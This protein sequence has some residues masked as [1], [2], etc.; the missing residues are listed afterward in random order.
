MDRRKLL[1]DLAVFCDVQ[2]ARIKAAGEQERNDYAR[3]TL[4]I[5]EHCGS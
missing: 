4:K 3:K 5:Q 2:I 1:E